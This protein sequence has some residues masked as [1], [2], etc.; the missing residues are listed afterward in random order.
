[1]NFPFVQYF[2]EDTQFE[3]ESENINGSIWAILKRYFRNE[4]KHK[5][6]ENSSKIHKDHVI[7]LLTNNHVKFYDAM[8]VA[9]KEQSLVIKLNSID[10]NFK[11]INTY[12]KKRWMFTAKLVGFNAALKYASSDKLLKII[13]RH[14]VQYYL[15]YSAIKSITRQ[16]QPQNLILFKAENFQA[17]AISRACKSVGQKSIAIQHGLIPVSHSQFSNLMVDEYFVWGKEFV[18]RLKENKAGCKV[19]ISGNLKS[20]LLFKEKKTLKPRNELNKI[21]ALPNSGSSHTSLDDV[22]LLV[23][24]LVEAAKKL[25][26]KQ[27]FI[28]PHPADVNNNVAFILTK[29]D[30]PINLNI[31]EKNSKIS[32]SEFELIIINNST[33]GLEAAIFNIPQVVVCGAKENIMVPQYLEYKTAIWADS[34]NNVEKC[35]EQVLKK[36]EFHKQQCQLLTDDF[37]SYQGEAAERLKHLLA[38]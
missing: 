9:L 19:Q 31:I 37:I 30:L 13:E 27:F 20:D 2:I 26:S 6:I 11:S 3:V 8:P 32:F 7:I 33:A 10:G 28:K 5:V 36:K 17:R 29:L 34:I 14:F 16:V 12:F 22:I 25:P 21:L 24:G 1:M 23:D 38:C 18:K 35:I 15:L 4:I